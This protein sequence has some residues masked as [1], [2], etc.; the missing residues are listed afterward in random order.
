MWCKKHDLGVGSILKLIPKSGK[1]KNTIAQ[2]ISTLNV[3]R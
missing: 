3:A 2:I 1:E